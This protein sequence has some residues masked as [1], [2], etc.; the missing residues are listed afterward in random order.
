M[1]AMTR[2]HAWAIEQPSLRLFTVMVRVLLAGLLLIPRTATLGALIELPIIVNIFAITLAIGPAFAGTR[3]VTGLML[4][5]DIYLL[6][7]DWDRWKHVLPF[8]APTNGRHGDVIV[9][10][11]LLLAAGIGFLGVTGTHLARLRHGSYAGPLAMVGG[12]ALLG[13][14]MLVIGC[15]RAAARSTARSRRG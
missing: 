8:E 9:S 4:L 12:G 2:L 15:R 14:A 5:A 11:G 3:I 7:W 6:C 1:G 10:L 13:A